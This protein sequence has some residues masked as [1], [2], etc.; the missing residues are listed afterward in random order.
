MKKVIMFAASLFLLNPAP[1]H[2]QVEVQKKE[3]F[4]TKISKAASSTKEGLENFGHK[5]GDAIGFDD[6]V[7]PGEDLIRVSGKS[8]MPIYT[9]NVYSDSDAEV[10]RKV[11]RAKFEEKYPKV[12]VMF[13][14]IPQTKWLNEP[15]MRDNIVI[16]YLETLYCYVT[17]RDGNDGYINSKFTFQRYKDVGSDYQQLAEKWPKWERVD[18]L[19]TKVYKKLLQK[20][21]M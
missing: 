11:C 7:E 20:M 10:Y 19:T 8:Y 4:K 12:Q 21:S 13:V 16:G 1:I 9:V 17:G 3:S 14:S 2:A 18:I 6:R 15:V 5:I